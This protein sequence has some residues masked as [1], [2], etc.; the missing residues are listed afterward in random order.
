MT[1]DKI[2]KEIHKENAETPEE[3]KKFIDDRGYSTPKNLEKILKKKKSNFINFLISTFK[4]P[5]SD[6]VG[7]VYKQI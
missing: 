7:L 1:T 6:G 2:H 5:I 3:L 4:L